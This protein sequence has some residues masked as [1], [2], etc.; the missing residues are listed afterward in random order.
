MTTTSL[1]MATTCNFDAYSVVA[2]LGSILDDDSI[3]HT[4]ANERLYM[5]ECGRAGAIDGST[6]T[7]GGFRILNG[8]DI[9]DYSPMIQLFQT[10]AKARR[11]RFL[12]EDARS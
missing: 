3:L 9:D 4:F 2:A 1:V 12:L 11:I 7:A 8:V 10:I 6:I 5:Q